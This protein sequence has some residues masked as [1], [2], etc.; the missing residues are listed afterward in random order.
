MFFTMLERHGEYMLQRPSG[1]LY[2]EAILNPGCSHVSYIFIQ[3]LS[4]PFVVQ[5]RQSGI[6]RFYLNKLQK[7][8]GVS[9]FKQT[10]SVT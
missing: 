10:R 1:G 3:L 8:F 2:A 7:L 5:L 9:V 6:E 4:F